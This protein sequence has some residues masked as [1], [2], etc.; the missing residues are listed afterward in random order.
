MIFKFAVVA[1]G[2]PAIFSPAHATDLLPPPP[3]ASFK[4]AP[5]VTPRPLW[6]GLYLGAHAGAALNSAGYTDTYDFYGDPTSK[7]GATGIGPIAG[8]QAGY[9]IARGNFVYGLEADVGYLDV[10]TSKNV[11]LI[12]KNQWLKGSYETSSNV[13]GDIT[14]R[15]GFAWDRT[16]L[17]VKGGAAV[18][19]A[20]VNANYLG[21]V[22]STPHAYNFSNSDTLWGWTAGA[23]AEYQFS[24]SW[25]LKAEYR[26]F[27]FGD[28]SYSYKSTYQ[29]RTLK[30]HADAEITTD[31]VTLGFNRYLN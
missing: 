15:V 16:L 14:G 2:A 10:S 8:V 25:S 11:T 7:F 13:Y 9:N 21:L 4:D 28:L 20:D 5:F 26:H 1:A 31:T 30:G 3:S 18:L 12:P 23:G 24:P 27:D 22:H 17:Y 19:G 29:G 6:A